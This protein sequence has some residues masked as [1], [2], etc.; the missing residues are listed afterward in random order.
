MQDTR[1]RSI[2]KGLSWRVIATLATIGIVFIFTGNITVSLG[3]GVIEVIAKI[4]FYYV[5]ERAWNAVAWGR[6]SLAR[7]DRNPSSDTI[8]QP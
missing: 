2:A 1:I 7:S 6:H 8:E 5:H 4:I 3:V